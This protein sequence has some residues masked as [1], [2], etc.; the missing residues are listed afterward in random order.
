MTGAVAESE[1]PRRG[2][3]MWF[4]GR[5]VGSYWDPLD[6]RRLEAVAKVHGHK[7]FGMKLQ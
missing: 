3:A 6:H 1:R 7:I 5:D 4:G 2:L